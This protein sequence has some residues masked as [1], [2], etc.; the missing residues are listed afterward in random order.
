MSPRLKDTINRVRRAFIQGALGIFVATYIGPL[1]TMLTGVVNVGNGNPMPEIDL[2]FWRNALL[3]VVAGG[4]IAVV[5]LAH[6]AIN[7]YL[8]KS[9]EIGQ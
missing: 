3:A 4:V 8:G 9:K 5:S 7:D 2:T 6:N 1:M